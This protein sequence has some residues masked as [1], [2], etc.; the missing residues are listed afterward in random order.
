MKKISKVAV[1]ALAT[2]AATL[3]VLTTTSADAATPAP[4][5]GNTVAV[6]LSRVV[7][8]PG[9]ALANG[10]TSTIQVAGKTFGS[11]TVPANA[12]AIEGLLSVYEDSGTSRLSIETAGTGA[13]GTPTVIGSRTTVAQPSGAGEAFHVALSSNGQVSVHNVGAATHFLLAISGYDVPATTC[14][15]QVFTIPA[16]Q[17]TLTNVG[18]SIKTRFTDAGSVTLPAGTYD[19]RIMGGFTG[20]NNSATF[21]PAG[22]FLTGTML[23]IKGD[24]INDDFSNDITDGGVMIPRSDSDSLTQD[25]T[26]QIDTFMT[27]AAPTNVHLGFFAYESNSGTAGSGQVHANVQSAVFRSVC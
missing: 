16:G 24:T 1:A 12:T 26:T 7:N 11:V 22:E 9:I 8:V 18:G 2:T 15:S 27:L 25:P 21:L 4:V 10:G 6:P 5:A 3:G 19:T 17:L 23:L 20:L 14:Q 13:P